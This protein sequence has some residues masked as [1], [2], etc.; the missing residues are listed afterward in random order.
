MSRGIS[1]HADVAKI[2]AAPA[3]SAR[4]GIAASDPNASYEDTLAS[5]SGEILVAIATVHCTIITSARTPRQNATRQMTGSGATRPS[6]SGEIASAP[7]VQT[8]NSIGL[9]GV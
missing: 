6:T 5:L 9:R 8:T 7:P 2:T 1:V 3:T 4:S